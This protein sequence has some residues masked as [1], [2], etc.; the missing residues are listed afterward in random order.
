MCLRF[1]NVAFSFHIER[2]V[3]EV[4]WKSI[5]T[6]STK[7]TVDGLFLLVV[8]KTGSFVRSNAVKRMI[9]DLSFFFSIMIEVEYDAKRDEKEQHE[10]K[11]K[12]VHLVEQ[13]RKDKE[14]E[15]NW[16]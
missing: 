5:Y 1:C 10:A 6:S 14:A 16:S 9:N 15:S 4:P 2:L 12:E 11:M 13:L 7:A 8:P 3:L